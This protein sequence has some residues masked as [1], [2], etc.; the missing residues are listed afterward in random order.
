MDFA[1]W[2]VDTLKEY[3]REL[4]LKVSGNKSDLIQRLQE[5][6]QGNNLYS[7]MKMPQLKEIL[8]KRGLRVSGSKANLIQRLKNDDALAK[9]GAPQ[10]KSSPRKGAPKQPSPKRSPSP[11]KQ[12]SPERSP[13]PERKPSPKRSPS[14]KKQSSPKRGFIPT[15]AKLEPRELLNTYGIFSRKEWRRWMLKF[16]PD[17]KPDTD[18]ELV[19]LINIAIDIVYP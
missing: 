10:R 7:D 4:G 16:H 17:K 13:T 5:Y 9:T 8:K 2:R 18:R 12:P 19:A 14:P 3:L 1:Q 11:K 15:Y 6:F